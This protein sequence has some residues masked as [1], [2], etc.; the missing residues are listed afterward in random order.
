[1][2]RCAQRKGHGRTEER[3]RT[4]RGKQRGKHAF[5]EAARQSGSARCGEPSGGGGR[6][7]QLKRTKQVQREEK[8]HGNHQPNKPRVLE[9]DAPAQRRTGEFQNGYHRGQQ[10]KGGQNTRTGR[11]KTQPDFPRVR[12]RL[13]DAAELHA[14]YRQYAGHQVQDQTAQQCKGQHFDCSRWRTLHHV[15]GGCAYGQLRLLGFIAIGDD[16]RQRFTR[17][18]R[19]FIAPLI[20]DRNRDLKPVSGVLNHRFAGQNVTSSGS[21]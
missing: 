5:A 11:Q 9:L 21:K 6:Q 17:K 18:R 20:S 4:R 1:M 16:K 7:K 15:C 13:Q 2:Q 8:G 19:G 14:H 10:H 12:T 3:R